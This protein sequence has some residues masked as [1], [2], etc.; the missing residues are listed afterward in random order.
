M[1]VIYFFGGIFYSYW[2]AHFFTEDYWDYRIYRGFCAELNN[3]VIKIIFVSGSRKTVIVDD[4]H[5]SP[6]RSGD[7]VDDGSPSRVTGQDYHSFVHRDLDDDGDDHSFLVI[8]ISHCFGDLGRWSALS[9]WPGHSGWNENGDVFGDRDDDGDSRV[10]KWKPA[11]FPSGEWRSCCQCTKAEESVPTDCY[12]LKNRMSLRSPVELYEETWPPQLS[13]V[14]P[15][16][17]V[18]H[19]AVRSLS[20]SWNS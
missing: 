20:R 2:N 4:G 15:R 18:R 16:A 1:C 3:L 8:R 17:L 6:W 13:E 10:L 12:C 7:G 14:A 5:V 9:G 19:T 11:H